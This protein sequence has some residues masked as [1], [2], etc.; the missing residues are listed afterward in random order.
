MRKSILSLL[1]CN[2]VSR[3]ISQTPGRTFP[4]FLPEPLSAGD[5]PSLLPPEWYSSPSTSIC[6]SA[7]LYAVSFYS[8][9]RICKNCAFVNWIFPIALYFLSQSHWIFQRMP[10][11][12]KEKDAW[13]T[14]P[15]PVSLPLYIFYPYHDGSS[16]LPPYQKQWKNHNP[17]DIIRPPPHEASRACD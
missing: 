3:A 7:L 8:A 14:I 12:F 1:T 11:S 13:H 10:Y 6:Y 4:F 5:G 9:N 15:S 17:P 16:G 2:G